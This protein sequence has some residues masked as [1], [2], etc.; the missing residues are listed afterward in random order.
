MLHVFRDGEDAAPRER[1]RTELRSL[2]E[3]AGAKLVHEVEQAVDRSNAATLV[4]S[5]KVLELAAAVRGHD[6]DLVVV[7]D[8]LSG[9]QLRNIEDACDVRAIDRTQLILDIFASRADSFEGKAQ[10]A[11]AQL[12]Y[13]LPRLTGRGAAMSRLGGGVGTRGPGETKLE[14]DRRRIRKDISHLRGVVAKQGLRRRELRRRRRRQGVYS[15]SIVGYTNAGKTTLLSELARRYGDRRAQPGRDRLFDTLDVAT[16][17]IVHEGRTFVFTDTVGF[18]RELPH[19]LVDAFRATL[20]EAVD[21]DVIV[22]VAD[23][24]SNFLPEE[25][26][27]VYDVLERV[28]HTTAPVLTVFNR[29]GGRECELPCDPRAARTAAG[30][31][32]DAGFVGELLEAV[33]E[34]AGHR[35]ALL[36]DVPDDRPDIVGM[37]YRVARVLSVATTDAGMQMELQV[38]PRDAAPF[39]PFAQRT[40]VGGDYGSEPRGS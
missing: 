29:R 8:D 21:A 40:D 20:E 23:A 24:E 11:L 12:S 33:D 25:L 9:A 39:L 28:L 10:V 5:G 30:S 17:R 2:L 27:A 13:L 35:M 18:I 3:T 19:H 38:D 22:L 16:R 26:D 1:M 36:L 32:L 7:G 34:L 14:T 6:A 37:A 31:V 15:V 4:G